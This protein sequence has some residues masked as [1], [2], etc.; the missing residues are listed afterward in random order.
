MPF[1][2]L[3]MSEQRSSLVEEIHRGEHSLSAVCRFYEVSRPTA[4]KWLK[5]SALG[6]DMCGRHKAPLHS[7][8]K[9]SAAVEDVIVQARL[10]HPCWGGRKLKAFLERRGETGIPSPSTVTA[11]L[12]RHGLVSKEASLAAMPYKRFEKKRP[13]DMWQADFKG[14]FQMGDGNRCHPLTVTDDMSR[15][16]LCISAKQNERLPGVRDSFIALFREYG[17]PRAVLCDNGAPFG[18]GAHHGYTK[19]EVFLMDYG[20]FPV[21][22]RP[23][24]PQTQGKCERFHRTM[25]RELLQ[26]VSI[27]DIIHAQREFDAFRREYNEERPHCSLDYAVPAERYTISH[28][29]MPERIA[30]WDYPDKWQVKKVSNKGYLHLKQKYLFLSEGFIG[31]NVAMAETA[32]DGIFEIIYRNFRIAIFDMKGGKFILRKIEKLK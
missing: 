31:H 12:Q 7:P 8:R 10:Q 5:R 2:A 15:F 25:K 4:Y 23:L 11:I 27:A 30:Q 20:V 16:N 29:L 22:G 17:L 9:T 13:N 1:G 26:R 18:T 24:H 6:E 32:D 28:R 21:H 14:H 3:T 19:F